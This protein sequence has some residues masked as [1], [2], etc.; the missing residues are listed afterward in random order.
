[1]LNDKLA[2]LVII[3]EV[4]VCKQLQAVP[5]FQRGTHWISLIYTEGRIKDSFNFSLVSWRCKSW[6]G[7]TISVILHDVFVYRLRY[8]LRFFISSVLILTLSDT[9]HNFYCVHLYLT[10]F[11]LTR[12]YYYYFEYYVVNISLTFLLLVISSISL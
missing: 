12:Y 7:H 4:G 9:V 2:F 10:A 6:R 11:I 3:K 1:M 5:V 8:F